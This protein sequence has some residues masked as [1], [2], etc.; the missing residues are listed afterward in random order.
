MHKPQAWLKR[1]SV[2]AVEIEKLGRPI[3]PIT[4]GLAPDAR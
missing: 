4:E 3:N 1:G 2:V